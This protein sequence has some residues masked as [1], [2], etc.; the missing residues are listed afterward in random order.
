MLRSISAVLILLAATQMCR[1]HP[2]HSGSTK[3]SPRLPCVSFD[4]GASPLRLFNKCDTCK[5]AWIHWSNGVND[6]YPVA[7]GETV[8]VKRQSPVGQI[9]KEEDC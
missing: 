9:F 1:S 5:V 2:V 6:S 7:G 3:P 8:D 4:L